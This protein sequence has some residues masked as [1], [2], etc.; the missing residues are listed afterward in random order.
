MIASPITA[1]A[2]RTP[3][4]MLAAAGA[5]SHYFGFRPDAVWLERW[6]TFF[7]LERMH[8]AFDGDAI[9]GGA[10]AFSLELTVPG[11]VVT[12]AGI[13]IVGVLPTHRRR[14][15]LTALMRAQLDDVRRRGEPVA[16]LWASEGTIYERFGYGLAVM[17][18]EMDI[19]RER[20]RFRAPFTPLGAARVVS[21]DEALAILPLIYDRMR[22]C[23]PGMLSR[24][25][26][27]WKN[28]RMLDLPERRGGGGPLEHM[29]LEVDGK[30]EAY[31]L[32]RMH[33]DV[34]HGASTGMVDVL[35]AIGTSPEATRSLW[36]VLLDIDWMGSIRALVLSADHPL[37]L[38][39]AEPRRANFRLYDTLWIRLVDVG[40]ALAARSFAGDASVVLEVRDGFRESNAGRWMIAAGGV[41]RTDAAAEVALD[42]SDLGAVYLGGFGFRELDEAGRVDELR[43]GALARA[44]ALFRTKRA[45]YNAEMF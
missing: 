30:P 20:T 25:P 6:L 38:L 43:P 2:C 44:D 36:R 34:E 27:W 9:V 32:Y 7:E 29:V 24:S 41:K 5:I 4:E 33:F 16:C 19:P 1:R 28:R 40:G 11:G 12:A 39:L 17:S 21:T 14:G 10:G 45:P 22:A 8:A 23:T 18:M 35:E 31:A 13:S 37:R 3:D 26:A 42:V 15:A